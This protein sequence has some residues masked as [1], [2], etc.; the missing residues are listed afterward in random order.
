MSVGH[1]EGECDWK[2]FRRNRG[3]GWGILTVDITLFTL[4]SLLLL[5]SLPLLSDSH[6][7][8]YLLVENHEIPKP[9]LP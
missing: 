3:E 4:T 2:N 1:L 8:L 6:S 5:Q 9:S 7:S